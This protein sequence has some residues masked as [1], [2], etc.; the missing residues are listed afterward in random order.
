MN[1]TNNTIAVLKKPYSDKGYSIHLTNCTPEIKRSVVGL[2]N[3]TV[4]SSINHVWMDAKPFLQGNSGEWMMLEFWTKDL[5]KIKCACLEF[6]NVIG[7]P[8][9]LSI[10]PEIL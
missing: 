8:V 2:M 7:L 10:V 4:I 3:N 5:E 6:G 1:S 9:D